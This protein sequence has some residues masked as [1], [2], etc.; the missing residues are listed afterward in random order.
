MKD[1]D[2]SSPGKMETAAAR[3]E[4]AV[5]RLEAAMARPQPAVAT[6]ATVDADLARSVAVRLD[7]AIERIQSLLEA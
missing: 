1:I 2:T 7:A 6:G 4:R 5:A 3:L